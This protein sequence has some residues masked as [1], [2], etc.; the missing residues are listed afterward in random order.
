MK[1]YRSLLVIACCLILS[2]C[3]STRDLEKAREDMGRRADQLQQKSDTLDRRI[4]SLETETQ[5][6]KKGSQV[7]RQTEAG[8]VADIDDTRDRMNQLRGRIEVLEKNATDMKNDLTGMQ[9][10]LAFLMKYLDLDHQKSKIEAPDSGPA[11]SAGVKAKT[12]GDEAYEIAWNNFRDEN[13]ARARSEFEAYLAGYPNESKAADACFWIA[14]CYYFENNFDKAVLQYDKVVKDYPQSG[15]VPRALYKEG[16][17]F[18]QL[19]DKITAKLLLQ[20]VAET[21]P[22]TLEAKIA[23]K[24]IDEMK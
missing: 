16:L 19:N 7:M 22:D 15:K 2:A 5:E 23:Q 14:E 13:F 18:Y 8:E 3:A 21:Y 10:R 4:M 1:K 20:Q 12:N 17:S 11:K 24:K 6:L 9:A